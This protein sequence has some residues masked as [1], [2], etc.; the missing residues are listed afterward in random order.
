MAEYAPF[1]SAPLSSDVPP[2]DTAV[3]PGLGATFG[4]GLRVGGLSARGQLSTLA[5]KAMQAAGFDGSGRLAAGAE[6]Q[7]A[8]QAAG[9]GLT[10]I[11]DV[12]DLS[13]GLR[14]ASGAIG[15]STPMAAL[16]TGASLLGGR[17]AAGRMLAGTAAMTPFEMGEGLQRMDADPVAAGLA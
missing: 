8:A 17:G 13:S 16:A 6:D 2:D 11:G 12:R 9:Q 10:P 3:Q 5:G 14:W 7:R 1:G 4:Q 15:A